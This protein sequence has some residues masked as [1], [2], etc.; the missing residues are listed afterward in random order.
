MEI[1]AN[2]PFTAP[3]PPRPPSWLGRLL[4][5][6]RSAPKRGFADGHVTVAQQRLEL[7]DLS[8]GGM[9]VAGYR[10]LLDQQDRFGFR[11]TVDGTEISGEAIVAWRRGDRM[12]VAFY[13][14]GIEA[15]QVLSRFS[16]KN[17]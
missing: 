3:A 5:R 14:L 16:V 4:R 11:L 9:C 6:D 13:A 2:S 8:L 17:P 12:G 10:G 7:V 1:A 15:Q